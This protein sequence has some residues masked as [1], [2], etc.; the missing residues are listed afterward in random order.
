V[1]GALHSRKW[2]ETRQ[3]LS[4]RLLAGPLSMS[5]TPGGTS[6]DGPSAGLSPDN[7]DVK[8]EHDEEVESLDMDIAGVAARNRSRYKTV[9]SLQKNR[10]AQQRFRERCVS[11]LQFQ[12]AT[13]G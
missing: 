4:M 10:L 5:S 7:E 12:H 8:R 13:L 1:T 6:A 3:W 11:V 9:E 2:P